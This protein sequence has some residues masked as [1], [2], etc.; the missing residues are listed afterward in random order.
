MLTK[1]LSAIVLSASILA[2]PVKASEVSF[3]TFKTP[4][5]IALYESG[6]VMVPIDVLGDV[7]S[8]ITDNDAFAVALA[9][10]LIGLTKDLNS[11]VCANFARNDQGHLAAR[12][13]TVYARSGCPVTDAVPDSY[14]EAKVYIHTHV[15]VTRYRPTEIDK[16]FL[17]QTYRARDYVGNDAYEFSEGDYGTPR[18]YLVQPKSVLYA[19][20]G[21]STR[22]VV[23]TFN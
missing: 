2:F 7:K 16:V 10:V 8:T 11:E 15:E 4:V 18:I 13:T 21:K 1:C 5:T 9:P 20:N 12:I 19:E 17:T 6:G 14:K 22:R 23:K 3:T